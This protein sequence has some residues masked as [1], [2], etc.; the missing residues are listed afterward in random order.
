MAQ[1]LAE[2]ER[3]HNK[4][5]QPETLQLLGKLY[6]DFMDWQK[7]EA[8]REN[9]TSRLR[10]FMTFL[11]ISEVEGLLMN[12]DTTLIQ[13][14]IIEFVKFLSKEKQLSSYSVSA[15]VTALKS[16]YEFNEYTINW[17][18]IAHYTGPGISAT[19][20][21]AYEHS[22]IKRMLD[23]ADERERVIILLQ[24]ST[25]MREGALPFIKLGDLSKIE[26]EDGISIY[27]ITVY[28]GYK[29]DQ[30]ITYCNP[31]CYEAINS[32]LEFR[33]RFGEQ[34]MDP[35]TFLLR[36]QFDITDP[37][38]ARE[39]KIIVNE[40]TGRVVSSISEAT[41]RHIVFKLALKVGLRT[42]IN[43]KDNNSLFAKRNR[44]SNQLCHALRKFAISNMI[45]AKLEYNARERLVGHRVPGL[46]IHYDR[47]N[48]DEILDEYVKAIPYLTINEENRLKLENQKIKQRND[49]LEGEREEVISLQKQLEPLLALKNTLI[50]EGVLKEF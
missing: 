18:R 20:D 7:S 14:K 2:K 50:K 17:K 35:E 45:R 42:K 30:Y 26:K 48:Q 39:L 10:G 16:F 21:R 33:K 43:T 12:K 22:E 23:I 34:K 8:T 37:E 46:D 3:R 32:Y 29:K 36:E 49:I 24:C 15:Y 27:Q 4:R 40:K 11:N 38:Q 1:I 28:R 41:I 19:P 5:L 13:T 44:H 31:E 25:G 9:Y 47:R 6:E